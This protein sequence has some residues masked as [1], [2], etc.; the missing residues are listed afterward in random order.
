MERSVGQIESERFLF[1]F[2]L[3]PFSVSTSE[4]RFSLNH[5]VFNVQAATLF[6]TKSR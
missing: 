1:L 5:A 2:L 6:K 3:E 4:N